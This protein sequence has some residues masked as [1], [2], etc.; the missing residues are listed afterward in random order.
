MVVKQWVATS[1]GVT[2]E[3]FRVAY[4]LKC[5]FYLIHSFILYNLRNSENKQTSLFLKMAFP[6]QYFT[7]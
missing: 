6:N 7:I 3:F 5:F 2:Q 1:N 4:Y